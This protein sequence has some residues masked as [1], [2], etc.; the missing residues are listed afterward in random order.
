MKFLVDNALS[1]LIAAG[2]R[3]TGHDAVHVRDIRMQAATDLEIFELAKR[4]S[5]IIISADTDFATLLALG[6][7]KYPSVIL[8]RR[9]L[10]RPENQLPFLLANLPSLETYLAEGS[11]V[12]LEDSRI[13]FRSLP[14]IENQ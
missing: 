13:R 10:R 12:V 4:E 5:R 6:Q 14:I 8:F 3:Q 2:L 11:I 9:S 7:R 1:P